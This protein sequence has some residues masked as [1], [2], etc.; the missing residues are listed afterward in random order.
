[1][2]SRTGKIYDPSEMSHAEF[3]KLFEDGNKKLFE[4]DIADATEKQRRES[5]VSLSDHR[6]PLGKQLT[7]ERRKRGLMKNY[8][9]KLKR[10]G[11]LA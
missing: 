10:A 7:E 2:D 6:S 5:A 8:R 3:A 4:I 1:M 11:K 9:R